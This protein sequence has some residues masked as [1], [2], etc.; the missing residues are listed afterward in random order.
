MISF[1]G[2]EEADYG[3]GEGS[4]CLGV[5]LFSVSILDSGGEAELRCGEVEKGGMCG[6]G[7][8][9]AEGSSVLTRG[10]R[11]VMQ[12][13]V[14]TGVSCRRGSRVMSSDKVSRGGSNVTGRV[15]AAEGA[16]CGSG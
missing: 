3:P 14:M 8:A 4:A 11:L 12:I 15:T 6:P 5:A 10:A 13:F 1:S 16:E 9:G 7:V 2:G